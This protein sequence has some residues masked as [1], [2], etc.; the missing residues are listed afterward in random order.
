VWVVEATPRLLYPRERPSS[1][2]VWG[3]VGNRAGVDGAGNLAPSEFRSPDRPARSELL[4]RLSYRGPPSFYISN[5]TISTI[6]N[7]VSTVVFASCYE[8][9][10]DGRQKP[11]LHTVSQLLLRKMCSLHGNEPYRLLTEVSLHKCVVMWTRTETASTGWFNVTGKI[12]GG[13]KE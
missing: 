3:W 13:G 12:L 7:A 8:R 9:K 4:Y 1:H 10:L 5:L 11:Q 2:C 6:D